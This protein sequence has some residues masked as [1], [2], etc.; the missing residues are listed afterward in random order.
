VRAMKASVR[1]TVNRIFEL[2]PD[3]SAPPSRSRTRPGRGLLDTVG[4][5]STYLFGTATEGN[6]EGMKKMINDIEA[7][8]GTA[9]MRPT[10]EKG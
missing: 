5:V 10:P 7:M 1:E 6:V 9:T 2:I 4:S 3:I 8:A